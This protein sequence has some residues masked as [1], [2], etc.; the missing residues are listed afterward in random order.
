MT[1]TPASSPTEPV[2]F[3]D[4]SALITMAVHAP[5]QQAVRKTLSA[6]R[7]VLLGVVVAELEELAKAAHPTAAWATTALC[8]LDWL[9][10]P[11]GVDEPA[12]VE[13]AAEIQERIAAGRPLQHPLQHYGEAAIISLA[14]RAR[15]LRPIM[16]SDDY[17]ARIAA[18]AFDVQSVSVHKL[19]HLMIKQR[20][21]TG[22]DAFRFVD[23]LNKAGRAQDYTLGE[24]ISGRL[25]RVGQP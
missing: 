21:V 14:S 4:T 24:L 15:Q 16:L 3:P 6:H 9:G 22:E 13:L 12:G 11:V 23:V 25:G 8:Q 5:L 20:K 2:W 18:K 17:D 10:K 1:T 7:R 19:I